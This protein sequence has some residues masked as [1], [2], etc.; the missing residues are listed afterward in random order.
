LKT[1]FVNVVSHEFR[2]PLGVIV[3]AADIL[4][5]YFE[6][7]KPD[8]RAGHLQDIR[9]ATQ[10]M[11]GLMEEVLLLGK[12]EAGKMEFKPEPIDLQ[13]FCGRLVDEQI[14]ATNRKCPILLDLKISGAAA[15]DEM[16]LRHVF[17]NLL[18]NAVK[19]SPPGSQVHF[20]V[21]RDGDDAVFEVRD[22]GIGIPAADQKHLFEAFH[23]ARN[24]G[25]IP[26]TGLGLVIV[27]RCVDLHGGTVTF[28]SEPRHGTT[29]VVRLK[30][31]STVTRPRIQTPKG[32]AKKS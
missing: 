31:F 10:Q 28:E 18:S 26:G 11:T 14:S 12:V 13:N 8:Q 6:R 17:S 22:H 9:H 23:R 30:L 2:T 3:S 5:N 1:S 20:T 19:Y 32:K 15:G 4:D 7:L 25:E 27:K 24:V 16:L 21:N 29:F